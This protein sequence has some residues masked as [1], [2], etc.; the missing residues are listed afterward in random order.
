MLKTILGMFPFN[1]TILIDWLDATHQYDNLF[2]FHIFVESE[3]RD[4]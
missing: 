2:F 1:V 4:H 3:T